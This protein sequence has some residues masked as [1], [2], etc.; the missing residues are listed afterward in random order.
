MVDKDVRMFLL[1]EVIQTL[2][3]NSED[4]FGL[5]TVNYA[6]DMD[7]IVHDIVT[8]TENN[9]RHNRFMENPERMDLESTTCF[10]STFL[11]QTEL[12]MIRGHL[13]WRYSVRKKSASM[14]TC[15]TR[16]CTFVDATVLNSK[17][18]NNLTYG[19]IYVSEVLVKEV[20][21]KL[22]HRLHGQSKID[23]NADCIQTEIPIRRTIKDEVYKIRMHKRKLLQ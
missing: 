8:N 15:D 1:N 21:I 13:L 23:I 2:Y 3:K 10:G 7:D 12:Q 22:L 14:F 6:R 9:E 16:V 18:C 4:S 20:A 11:S 17:L 19:L 5:Q